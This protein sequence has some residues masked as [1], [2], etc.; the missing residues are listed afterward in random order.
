[1][2]KTAKGLVSFAKSKL[3]VEYVYG[4]KGEILTQRLYDE[5]KNRYGSLVWASDRNKIGKYCVDCSGLISWYTGKVRNSTSY[6]NT[7]TKI[8]GINQIKKAVPGCAVW[9]SGHIGIY[10]GNDEVIEAKGSAYGVVK[11]RVRDGNWTHI[12]WLSEIEYDEE[13]PIP[14]PPQTQY[15]PKCNYNG[16]SIVD[17]LKSIKVNSSFSY[18]S[19]IAKANGIK[20][21]IGLASQNST[22]LTRL[23]AGKLI[24]P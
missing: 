2:S 16:V 17:G 15:F 20:A 10:I 1:M 3:G 11:T 18:R 6:K 12:L 23:K 7:A 4:A 14:A 21:Y 5:L 8:L 24:K 19:K 9:R 13:K 22:M